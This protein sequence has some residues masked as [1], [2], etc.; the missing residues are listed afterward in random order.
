MKSLLQYKTELVDAQDGLAKTCGDYVIYA[1]PSAEIA[2][3]AACVRLTRARESLAIAES[4]MLI[5][6]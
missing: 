5:C 1:D 2:L 4:K 3:H 6:E